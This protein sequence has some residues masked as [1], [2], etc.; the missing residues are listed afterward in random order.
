LFKSEISV[1]QRATHVGVDLLVKALVTS[2]LNQDW[3]VAGHRVEA[4]RIGPGGVAH[5]V[6]DKTIYLI[7]RNP[8]MG[9]SASHY[10]TEANQCL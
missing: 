2:L 1:F 3:N 5:E 9:R 10:V 7:L 4:R 8:L 6:L